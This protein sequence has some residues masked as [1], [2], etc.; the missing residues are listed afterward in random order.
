M[1][2]QLKSFSMN[3]F[4]AF[5]FPGMLLLFCIFLFLLLTP[6]STAI[7]NLSLGIV[8][9]VIFLAFSYILGVLS[10]RAIP[11]IEELIFGGFKKKPD[12]RSDISLYQFKNDLIKAFKKVFSVE[13]PEEYFRSST[14]FYYCRAVLRL[15][16]DRVSY[17]AEWQ[18]DLYQLRRNSIIP[19]TFLVCDG[20]AWGINGIQNNQSAWGIALI[21]ISCLI[22]FFVLFISLPKAMYAN[23]KREARIIFSTFI[24]AQR[25]NLLNIKEDIVTK[26]IYFKQ[27]TGN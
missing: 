17:D 10:S 21:I 23:R 11:N 22:G 4:L 6:L 9:S 20:I 3:D 18:N 1:E 7:Q 25:L 26:Y 14:A 19:I 24:V 27:Q 5:L 13:N 15:K 2:D 8:T 12:P 16:Y